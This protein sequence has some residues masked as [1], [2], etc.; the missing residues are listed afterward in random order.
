MESLEISAKALFWL[1]ESTGEA[2]FGP[3]RALRPSDRCG[4]TGTLNEMPS[5]SH[6]RSTVPSW[7]F[8]DA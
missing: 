5:D 2:H 3:V 8:V 6:S 7:A 1:D 4:S